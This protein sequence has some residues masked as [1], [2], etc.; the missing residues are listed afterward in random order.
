MIE[1]IAKAQL[2]TQYADF[3]VHV[4][5][6]NNQEHLVLTKGTFSKDETI[7]TRIH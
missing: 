2:P 6:H 3:D 1:F 4:F 5:V 7:L